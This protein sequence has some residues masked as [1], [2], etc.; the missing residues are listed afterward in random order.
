MKE[1]DFDKDKLHALQSK[2][3]QA[4]RDGQ[5]TFQFEGHELSV[6]WAEHVA[7]YVADNFAREVIAQRQAD[8]VG[9]DAP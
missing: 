4:K 8:G 6:A 1:I 7:V 5:P 2:I 3:A 9:P